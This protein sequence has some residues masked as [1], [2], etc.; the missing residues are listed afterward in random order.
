MRRVVHPLELL[1][2]GY[3]A[4]NKLLG[5]KLYTSNLQLGGPGVMYTN[6]VV[7]VSRPALAH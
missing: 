5:Q 2:T 1:L 7:S 3:K 6:G 4:L